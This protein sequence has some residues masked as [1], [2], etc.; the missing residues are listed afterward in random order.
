MEF[1]AASEP[2]PGKSNEDCLIIGNTW[3][4]VLDGATAPPSVD[5]G[6]VHDVQWLVH[7]LAGH[8]ARILLTSPD[9][10]LTDV[11]AEA[12]TG[13][14]AA[15]ES[16]C[17]LRNPDSPS[18]TLTI[19]RRRNSHLDYL[20]LADSPIVVDLAGK[21]TVITDD[22]TAHLKDYSISGVSAVR[23]TPEGFYVAS[24]MP[25]AAYHAVY[26]SFEA[27]EVR[28]M[29]LL[30]DGASRLVDHFHNI[31]WAELLDL[32]ENNGP[33]ALLSRTR[34]V[35][36]TAEGPK[37]GRR[38]KLHDDATAVFISRSA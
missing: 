21:V 33:R 24:T 17:D 36:R 12:I 34:E 26:G 27:D 9:A 23:N 31:S 32:L 37:D 16:T 22:R 3:A 19:V 8:L 29:A 4:A 28:R 20:T 15:H 10:P 25:E 13:T 18:S 1:T 30:T 2:T 35:E 11:T 38:R 14:C 5:S 6:C 7:Q